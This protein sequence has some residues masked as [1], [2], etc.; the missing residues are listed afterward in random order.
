MY[1]EVSSAK[2]PDLAAFSLSSSKAILRSANSVLD[3]SLELL[4]TLEHL[5]V[6][7]QG[8]IDAKQR[9]REAKD[10]ASAVSS[11]EESAN[12][13]KDSASTSAEDEADLEESQ[14]QDDNVD[15]DEDQVVH[16]VVVEV[17][18]A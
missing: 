1:T 9:V 8:E 6:T 18:G 10:T 12:T 11:D 2:T 16:E 4:Q 17:D 3:R 5:Q 14:E 7:L 15:G 13:A